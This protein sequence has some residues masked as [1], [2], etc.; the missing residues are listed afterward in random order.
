MR[1]ASVSVMSEIAGGFE[2]PEYRGKLREAIGH[3]GVSRNVTVRKDISKGKRFG[4]VGDRSRYEIYIDPETTG[5]KS[6]GFISAVIKH[7]SIHLE[8]PEL[9]EGEVRRMT[10]DWAKERF[11]LSEDETSL[12]G[13]I[14]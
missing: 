1:R 11:D 10:F 9:S 8:Q 14:E 3:V 7:E 12:L 13:E 4:T 5:D 6:V 2:S